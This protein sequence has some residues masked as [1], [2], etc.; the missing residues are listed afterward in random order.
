LFFW[1]SPEIVEIK[2][3]IGANVDIDKTALLKQLKHTRK[4]LHVVAVQIPQSTHLKSN[5]MTREIK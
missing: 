4:T 1:T 3:S 5:D 2:T